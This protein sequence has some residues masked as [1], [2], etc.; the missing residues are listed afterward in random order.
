MDETEARRRAARQALLEALA[1]ATQHAANNML[2]VL[3][4]TADILKRV[5]QDEAGTKRAARIAE[6]TQKLEALLRGY[7]TL[8]RRPVPDTALA[9][10]GLLLT[11]LGVLVELFLPRGTT[12]EIH[13]APGLPRIGIDMSL[14]DAPLLAL[15]RDNATRLAP[16]LRIAA[17]PAA[18]GV[19]L[20]VEGLPAD[21]AAEAFG[22]AV[23]SAGG[24]VVALRPVLTLQL[25]GAAG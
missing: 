19:S 9:D 23:E 4:G 10:A 13:A 15:L 18:G 1:P 12:L 5:A 20:T 21:A 14:L 7:L 11:R 2:Q 8:A 6:A 24:T 16:V 22:A 3:G 17:A 25:P